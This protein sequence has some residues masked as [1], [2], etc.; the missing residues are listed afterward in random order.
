MNKSKTT[1]N[2]AIIMA[3][4]NGFVIKRAGKRY[5]EM[6]AELMSM[7]SQAKP[8]AMGMFQIVGCNEI[9]LL[10]VAK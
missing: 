7:A 2:S 6:T 5:C 8:M 4:T 3:M 10:D 1:I 9:G